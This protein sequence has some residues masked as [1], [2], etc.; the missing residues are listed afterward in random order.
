MPTSID[1]TENASLSY[2]HLWMNR[3]NLKW[4][5][6]WSGVLDY[7]QNLRLFSSQIM[8][9]MNLTTFT[10]IMFPFWMWSV[11]VFWLSFRD[12]KIYYLCNFFN[13]RKLRLRS[14]PIKYERLMNFI[15]AL[16][17]IHLFVK[18][19]TSS[20]THWIIH[21]FE[22]RIMILTRRCKGI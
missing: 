6:F 14:L 21:S 16:S 22:E 13:S 8:T 20:V 19:V 9:D 15:F 2:D 7:F 5:S 11:I 17:G 10:I 4:S 3:E 12:F 18:V 1:S